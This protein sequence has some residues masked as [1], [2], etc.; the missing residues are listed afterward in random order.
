M[1]K[2]L[3]EEIRR[4][5]CGEVVARGNLKGATQML[6]DVGVSS[7]AVYEED[8]ERSFLEAT[9]AF[10]RDEGA[11]YVGTTSVPAYLKHV[12]SRLRE[13]SSRVSHYLDPSTKPKLVAVVERELLSAHLP[14]LLG[15]EETGFLVMLR[16]ESTED[17]SRM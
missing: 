16:E 11:Q 14:A 7:T 17:L 5:R 6:V 12:E 8:F 3:L 4:V 10:Y 2:T 9:T 13:E 1:C 15:S